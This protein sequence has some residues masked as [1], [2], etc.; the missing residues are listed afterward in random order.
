MNDG[1]KV[2][3]FQG[4]SITDADRDRNPMHADSPN[5]FGSGYVNLIAAQLL[6]EQ[7]G[8]LQIYNRGV[9]GD[10]ILD[11]YARWKAECINLNPDLISILVGVNDTW[12]EFINRNGVSVERYETVYR[13]LL[14]DTRTK[15]PQ[16]RLVLCEPFVLLHGEVTEA[17]L[18]D[19]ARR[20]QVVK[21][22]ASDF[23]AV[24]VPFQAALD[25]AVHRAPPSC[26]LV[27]GVHPTA[28]GHHLL[29]QTWL[30]CVNG[31]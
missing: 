2:I 24:F 9:G 27:D 21:R 26:W 13:D 6:H 8:A 4:D 12:H 30:D 18:P 15:L 20:Q 19:I 3:V 16:V 7:P 14:I 31:Y 22:L 29:A 25:A 23:D 10:R 28:A 1:Q 17:W 5:A 11:L